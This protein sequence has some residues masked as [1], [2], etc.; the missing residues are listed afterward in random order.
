MSNAVFGKIIEN[1]R[2]HKDI[3]LVTTSLF[4]SINTGNA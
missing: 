2:K 3:R 4:I 1:V